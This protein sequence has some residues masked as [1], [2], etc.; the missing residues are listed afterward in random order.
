[1]KQLEERVEVVASFDQAGVHPLEFRYQGR[2][3][4]IKQ[5]HR[6][7]RNYALLDEESQCF[8]VETVRE[9]LVQLSFYPRQ[10]YWLLDK[11]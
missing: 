11:L 1:M 9:R 7:W 2:K 4:P 5:I 10:G 8:V 6:T 3:W